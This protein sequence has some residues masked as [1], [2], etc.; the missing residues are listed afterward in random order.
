VA[1]C[2]PAAGWLAGWLA[3]A[4]GGIPTSHPAARS[5]RRPVCRRCVLWPFSNICVEVFLLLGPE[6]AAPLQLGHLAERLDHHV[7]WC[8]GLI[9]GMA[10]TSQPGSSGVS[11][12]AQLRSPRTGPALRCQAALYFAAAPHMRQLEGTVLHCA[13]GCV[14][15]RRCG[16]LNPRAAHS[17]AGPGLWGVFALLWRRRLSPLL[18]ISWAGVGA[19]FWVLVQRR[20]E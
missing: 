7:V 10:Q 4:G 18:P 9:S 14:C 20:A 17:L 1:G 11:G 16:P 2:L 5:Q 3:G 8:C 12:G 15:Q 6:M 19:V 13:C